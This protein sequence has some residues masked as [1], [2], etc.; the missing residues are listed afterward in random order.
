MVCRYFNS[1]AAYCTSPEVSGLDEPWGWIS[2]RQPCQRCLRFLTCE[3]LGE[4]AMGGRRHAIAAMA[5]LGLLLATFAAGQAQA[6]TAGQAEA[7]ASYDRALADF[8]A[9]LT[10]R[11][12][13]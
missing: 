2:S 10:E 13:Q 8:K 6:L 1:K 12:N 4:P 5:A 7:V 3:S 11:R 9:I